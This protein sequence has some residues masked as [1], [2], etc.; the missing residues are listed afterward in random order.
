MRTFLWLLCFAFV[1][2]CVGIA[3]L[4]SIVMMSLDSQ[5]AAP[6]KLTGVFF[7]SPKAWLALPVPW[8]IAAAWL[9]RRPSPPPK[10]VFIY[11]GTLAVAAAFVL[12][13]MVIAGILPTLTFR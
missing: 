9:S 2:E 8:L 7:H 4:A 6:P 11:V 12:G 10:A 3:T 1:I 5:Q 13:V